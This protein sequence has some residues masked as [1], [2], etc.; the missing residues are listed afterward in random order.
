[1]I[2]IL[3]ITRSGDIEPRFYQLRYLDSELAGPAYAGT[4]KEGTK[5][6]LRT[7]MLEAGMEAALIDEVFAAVDTAPTNSSPAPIDE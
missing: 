2:E 6:Q 4:K 3:G 1:M 7:F 5:D